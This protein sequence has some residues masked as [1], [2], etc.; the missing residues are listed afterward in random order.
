[1]PFS[2]AFGIPAK[3][4]DNLPE[5]LERPRVTDDQRLTRPSPTFDREHLYGVVTL[6]FITKN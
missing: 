3:H 5:R 1:V 6:P 2:A 4:P